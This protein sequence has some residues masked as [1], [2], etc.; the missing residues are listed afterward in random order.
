MRNDGE[1]SLLPAA[2]DMPTKG[3]KMA[4]ARADGRWP[5]GVIVTSPPSAIGDRQSYNLYSDNMFPYKDENP[6]YLKPVITVGLVVLNLLAWFLV[7]GAGSEQALAESICELGLIPGDLLRRLPAGYELPIGQGMACVMTGTLAWH[8]PFTSMFLHGGWFHLLGNMWFLWVFGNNVEDAMGHA[9]F[10]V[11]Y[12]LC[13]LLAAAAQVASAPSSPV[14]MVGASG[15]I[16]GVMGA[17]LV[18]YPRVRVHTI[19][20]LGI[21]ITRATLPA[22]MMLVYW[23]FLQILGS[24]PAIAGAEAGGGVAFMAHLGGFAAGVVLIRLF[25]KPEFVERHRR[26]AVVGSWS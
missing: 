20:F 19:I 15:A 21:F 16:S 17:Y 25:A 26:P 11:F 8:T 13:G 1:Q 4:G 2:S 23:A 9:R 3:V 6:T 18:L 7:Q 22:W 10:V 24:L 5:T 14:P 12:L